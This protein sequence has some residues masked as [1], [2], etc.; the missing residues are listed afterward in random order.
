MLELKGKYCKDC[1]IFTDN[2]DSDAL[3]MMEPE[4]AA[5]CR[6][7]LQTV[8]GQRADWAGGSVEIDMNEEAD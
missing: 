2:I 1:K 5:R 7:P 6:P 8:K 4:L 3:S